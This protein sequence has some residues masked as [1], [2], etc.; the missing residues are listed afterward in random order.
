[1]ADA[2]EDAA[3]FDSGFPK[4]P[5]RMGGFARLT[6]TPRSFLF[7]TFL[8]GDAISHAYT[9]NGTADDPYIVEYLQ[10]D[11]KDALNFP[12]WL[13]LTV[14]AT[15]AL[16]TMLV[17]MASSVYAS[18]IEGVMRRF[19]V[20][21]EVATLGLA[22]YVLGFAVGPLFWA[23]IS[24]TYGRRFTYVVSFA[25]YTAFSVGAVASQN[26]QTLLILRFLASA[27]GSSCMTNSGAFIADMFNKEQ[28]GL[29]TSLYAAAPFFGPALGR[30]WTSLFRA[31]VITTLTIIPVST[32]SD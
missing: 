12:M 29:A 6:S 10:N 2:P 21:E 32:L 1:M 11:P 14:A 23:P 31:A 15:Q 16:S 22:L 9:G 7:P 20:S 18:D 5:Q 8:D 3:S 26:I 24:E 30:W 19:H 17:T 28:R 25:G 27:F 4:I 13:K